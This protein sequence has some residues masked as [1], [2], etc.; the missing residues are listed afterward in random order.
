MLTCFVRCLLFQYTT[1]SNVALCQCILTCDY[2]QC[3]AT[4]D[5][6]QWLLRL[7]KVAVQWTLIVGR[8]V[9]ICNYVQWLLSH[10]W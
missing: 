5:Y 1:W 7:F 6:V 3:D 9:T 8:L 10:Y 2:V 4:C